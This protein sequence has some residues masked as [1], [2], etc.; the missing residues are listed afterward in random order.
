MRQWGAISSNVS[1]FMRGFS[2]SISQMELR[3]PDLLPDIRKGDTIFISSDYGGQHSLAR[4]ETYTFVL[5]DIENC[6]TW[7]KLRRDW[8]REFL[9]DGRRLSYK[10]L[11]DKR[12]RK[13][14][15]PFLYTT[16]FIPGIVATILIDKKIQT[17][18]EPVEY[19]EMEESPLKNYSN[20]KRPV[21]EKL[22]RII[23]FVSLFLSGL[24]RP[25]QNVIWI[26][27]E[28]EIVPNDQRLR[29]ATNLF[30]IISSNYLDHTLGHF[31]WGT[32]K[33]DS[34][35]RQL[36]DLVS[37]ADL[38][39]GS[40]STIFSIYS[41]QDTVPKSELIIPPPHNM[42]RKTKDIMDW[43]SDNTRI[44]KRIVY[45]IEPIE[46]RA[47]L[48]LKHIRFHGTREAYFQ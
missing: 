2:E 13:A 47:G 6:I 41:E 23:H 1:G 16:N 38:A 36:E 4:Y 40:I 17:I 20:W 32:T 15:K 7:E 24:S 10:N 25:Y 33:L 45:A 14:L 26:T 9:S 34:G 31:R 44:L 27:D 29:E 30:A 19:V 48:N 35:E 28:D 37:I 5:A 39:A 11:N 12:C 22:L 21:F 18:F 8:R 46:G 43:F 3:H 42:P